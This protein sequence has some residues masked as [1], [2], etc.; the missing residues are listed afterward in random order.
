MDC[1]NCFNKFKENALLST[2]TQQTTPWAIK[3]LKNNIK[4]DI[5][6]R[7]LIDIQEIMEEY[8]LGILYII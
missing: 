7:E 3:L 5:D 2:L 4:P 8:K 1:L 6:I